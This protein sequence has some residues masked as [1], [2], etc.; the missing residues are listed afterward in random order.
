[1]RN[2]IAHLGGIFIH[3]ENPE[4]LAE[5]YQENFGLCYEYT[6]EYDARYL[7]FYYLEEKTNRKA[8][9]VFSYI[10]SENPLP[11]NRSF[12]INFRV[13]DMDETIGHLKEKGIKVKGPQD[14]PE[15]KFAWLNDPEG[16]PI[17]LWEDT[18]LSPIKNNS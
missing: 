10:K 9:L 3:S 6:K 4:Q 2:Q 8:Y 7:S 14:F 18:T 11:K 13:H 17:E 16:T 5:W 15:G 1:M 12:T